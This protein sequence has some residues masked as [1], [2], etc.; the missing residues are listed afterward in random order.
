MIGGV[1]TA[2]FCLAVT[3]PAAEVMYRAIE[4]P[5]MDFAR[6]IASRAS[7]ASKQAGA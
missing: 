7:A 6:G 3:I 5:G 1:L 4:R 2:I